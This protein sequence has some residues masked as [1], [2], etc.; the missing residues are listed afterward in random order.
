MSNVFEFVAASREKSGTSTARAVRRQGNVPAIIYGGS[1]APA[2]ITL[3]HNDVIKR[4]ENEAVYSHILEISVDGKAEKAVLKDLQRHPA[5]PQ[6]L[7]MDFM[8]INENEQLKMHV[9]LHFINENEALGVKKGGVATHA[10]VEVEISCLPSALPEYLQVDLENLDVGE[11]VHLSE[12]IL[13]EGVQ[14]VELTQGE[15]HD[16]AVASIVAS[17][18]SKGDEEE[19]EEETSAE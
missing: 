10:R 14:I 13:P 18:V 4:L 19:T 17:R 12:I 15:G 1:S 7:H 6:V 16:L 8:R 3:N 9:P 11:S 2:L 5:K